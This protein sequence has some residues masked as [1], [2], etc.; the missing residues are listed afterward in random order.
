MQQFHCNFS[1]YVPKSPFLSSFRRVLLTALAYA[2]FSYFTLS[3]FSQSSHFQSLEYRILC[4]QDGYSGA[5]PSPID[6]IP[7]SEHAQNPCCLGQ[8]MSSDLAISPDLMPF[9]VN[10]TYQIAVVIGRQFKLSPQLKGA[11]YFYSRAPPDYFA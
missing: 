11:I 4:Q 6:K 2:L 5:H 3:A 9:Y 10:L 7:T 1:F 8:N